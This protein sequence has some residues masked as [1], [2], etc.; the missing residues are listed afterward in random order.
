MMNWKFI[1]SRISLFSLIL[2]CLTG[3]FRSDYT[4]MV[5]S[6]L[7]KGVRQD[8]ILLGIRFGHTR[9]DFYGKCFDLN[10]QKLVSQGPS[11]SAVQYRFIDSLVHEEP[12]E[13]RLLFYPSF[14]KNDI[15]SDIDY[16]FSY[17]AWAPWN[18]KFQADSLKPKVME[19]MKVWYKGNDFV[20]AHAGDQDIPVKVDGNRRLM[21]F[22]KDKQTVLVRVQDIL[23]PKFKHSIE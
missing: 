17:M 13:L 9:N 20:I 23:H 3:C 7:D 16:E 18:K 1:S 22:I 2:I 15:I 8:S 19:L 12:T 4:E 14:D 11:N 10:K 6:E 5:L 21:V